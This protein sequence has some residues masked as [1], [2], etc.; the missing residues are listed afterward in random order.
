M[1]PQHPPGPKAVVGPHPHWLLEEWTLN[2]LKG[3]KVVSWVLG[4]GFG[5]EGQRKDI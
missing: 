3:L 5:D 1:G 4:T 2:L